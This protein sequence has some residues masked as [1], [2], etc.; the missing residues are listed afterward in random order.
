MGR[1]KDSL[2][3]VMAK[4]EENNA[5]I[6]SLRYVM[7]ILKVKLKKYEILDRKLQKRMND[8][9]RNTVMLQLTAE[10]SPKKKVQSKKKAVEIVEVVETKKKKKKDISKW[11]G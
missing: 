6:Y 10:P 2:E 8:P 5:R 9:E 3:V 1:K 4:F 7:E 11:N